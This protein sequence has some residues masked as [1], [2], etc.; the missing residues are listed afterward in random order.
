ME[1]DS[2]KQHPALSCLVTRPE[3]GVG[4]SELGPCRGE[5]EGVE[6]GGGIN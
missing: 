6:A 4:G 3:G 1:R 5:M 2:L